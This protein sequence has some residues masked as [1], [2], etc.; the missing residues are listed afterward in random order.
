MFLCD[1]YVMITSL[2]S[3]GKQT[4]YLAVE[5]TI[6]I[7]DQTITKHGLKAA[8]HIIFSTDHLVATTLSKP[9]PITGVV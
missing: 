9:V 1:L 7:P 8:Y 6:Q 4:D 5:K 3:A 2:G